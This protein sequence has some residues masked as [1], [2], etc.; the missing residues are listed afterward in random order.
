V[1]D[2]VKIAANEVGDVTENG[3]SGGVDLPDAFVGM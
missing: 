3:L 1:N 2:L